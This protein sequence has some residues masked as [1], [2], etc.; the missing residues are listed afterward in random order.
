MLY[1]HKHL[2]INS[3]IVFYHNNKTHVQM[4]TRTLNN[5]YIIKEA[6]RSQMIPVNLKWNKINKVKKH[7]IEINLE[8]I[9]HYITLTSYYI[10]MGTFRS[11]VITAT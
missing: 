10:V 2:L 7:Y 8:F 4:T 6:F 3:G 1:T 5:Y 11:Q 9:L